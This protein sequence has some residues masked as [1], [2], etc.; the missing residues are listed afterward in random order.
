VSL[1][2]RPSGMYDSYIW[3]NGVR[4]RRATRTKNRRQAEVVEQKFREELNLQRHGIIQ[5]DPDVTVGEL[6]VQFISDGGC[7]KYHHGRL[8]ELLPFWSEILALTINKG[9]AQ[10]YRLWRHKQKEVGDAT[11]N[12]D[13]SVVRH[14]LY[15]AVDNTLLPSNPLA[16]LRMVRERRTKKHV[17]SVAE[18]QLLLNGC[19]EYFRPIVVTALDTGMRRGELL[20]QQLRDI[21][22]SR[23]VLYVTRSKTP[24]GE[25]R[26][27]P[28]TA[29]VAALLEE[30]G[31]DGL[32]FTYHNQ[33]IKII[34]TAWRSALRRSG[35]PKLRFHDLRHTFNTRLMEAGVIQDIRKALMGHS[36]GGEV[37]ATYTHVELP[38]KREAIHKLELWMEAEKKKL[39]DEEKGGEHQP[40]AATIVRPDLTRDLGEGSRRTTRGPAT[41]Q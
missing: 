25:A 19:S 24:E 37:H 14:I 11:I 16:R 41:L 17:L 3:I 9:H 35:I 8:K 40:D 32:L 6:V 39:K 31:R 21:D 13:L 28:L 2:R 20:H 38:A 15:W 10:E 7:T 36:S 18:E 26:E 4:Y 29:R 1:Y 33:S 22:T 5:T 27:I 23:G 30:R 12:R 34:K